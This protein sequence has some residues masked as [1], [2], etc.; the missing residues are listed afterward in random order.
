MKKINIK[1]CDYNLIIC[2]EL[3]RGKCLGLTKSM[4]KEIYIVKDTIYNEETSQTLIHELLHAYFYESGC[5]KYFF[6]EDLI[7]C[8]ERHFAQILYSYTQ[9]LSYLFPKS[10]DKLK[11][12][13]KIY[14]D[15]I[16]KK[17]AK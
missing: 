9:G 15:I 7:R 12:A 1:G 4:D 16:Y 10:K 14:K 13:Y 11:H 8:L 5:D 2:D 6:D 3:D 17:E